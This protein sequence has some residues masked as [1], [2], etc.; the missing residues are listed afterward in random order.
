[1]INQQK[2][3][4]SQISFSTRFNMALAAVDDPARQLAM[5][6]PSTAAVEHHDWLGTVPGLEEWKDERKMDSL[7]A[8]NIIIRNKDFASGIRINRNDITDDRLGI[9]MP[10]IGR[11]AEKAGLHYGKLLVDLLVNGFVTTSEFGA[12]YDGKAF[13]AADHQDGEDGPVQSNTGA[14]TALSKAAYFGARAQMWTLKDEAGDPLGIVPNTLIVGPDLEE[15]ALEI[16]EAVTV[17]GGAGPDAGVTNVA[18]GT[19]SLII[20][21]RL[22]GAH[23]TKWFLASLGG[24][25]RPLIL[26]IREAL[27]SSFVGESSESYFKS[28]KLQFGAEGRHNVGYGLWQFIYG[29]QGA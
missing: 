27:T 1:M 14:A 13:F 6:V 28:K 29:N 25:M 12:A 3:D 7:R 16:L 5:E 24:E 8:E 18:R 10:K 2:I 21:P 26:Q 20:S 19:A 4:A 11:L 22:S 15:K 23:A 9:V 17:A